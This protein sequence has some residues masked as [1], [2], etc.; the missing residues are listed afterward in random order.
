[1][2]RPGALEDMRTGTRQP[3]W[4]SWLETALPKVVV[5]PS[6]AVMVIFI[7]GFILWTL[8]ISMTKSTFLP[9]YDFVG[10]VQYAKLWR[11]ERWW[12]ACRNLLVYGGLFI[13]L[14]TTFGLLLAIF[15]DQKIRIEG[16]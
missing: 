12:V 7:Y 15:L 1:M 8:Y 9:T 10:L 16:A 14:C 2:H 13:V 11:I 4:S 6:F 3:T 5:A